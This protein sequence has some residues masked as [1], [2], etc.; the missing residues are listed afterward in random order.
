MTEKTKY[1]TRKWFDCGYRDLEGLYLYFKKRIAGEDVKFIEELRRVTHLKRTSS[2]FLALVTNELDDAYNQFCRDRSLDDWCNKYVSNLAW[3]RFLTS[4]RVAKNA[5]L[6][7]KTRVLRV[8]SATAGYSSDQLVKTLQKTDGYEDVTR[9]EA[10]EF[11]VSVVSRVLSSRGDLTELVDGIGD[12]DNIDDLEKKD[13]YNEH[14]G[15]ELRYAIKYLLV[16][17]KKSVSN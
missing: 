10:V 15:E 7:S 17:L 11:A 5:N 16:P 9:A 3:T 13:R 2:E 6:M 14:L 4:L 1:Y 12:I 8:T